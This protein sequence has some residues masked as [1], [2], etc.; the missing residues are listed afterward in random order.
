MISTWVARL[1]KKIILSILQKAL[2][3][4]S[5]ISSKIGILKRLDGRAVCLEIVFFLLEGDG[6]VARSRL[7]TPQR[8]GALARL[9][10]SIL[11]ECRR[12]VCLSTGVVL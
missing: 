6:D 2:I 9:N 7:L 10:E 11:F 4:L 1:R 3:R 8:G 12:Y 5:L